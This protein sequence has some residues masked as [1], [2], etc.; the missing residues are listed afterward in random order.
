MTGNNFKE[1]KVVSL[2]FTKFR[3]RSHSNKLYFLTPQDFYGAS[4]C[5]KMISTGS[6]PIP[7][8]FG[9]KKNRVF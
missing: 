4:I 2:I 9:P 5:L 1:K 6:P 8:F 7:R 3:I